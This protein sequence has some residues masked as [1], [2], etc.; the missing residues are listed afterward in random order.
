MDV[1]E[2]AQANKLDLDTAMTHMALAS[3]AKAA[4]SDKQSQQWIFNTLIQAIDAHKFA[5]AL[6][7]WMREVVP[8]AEAQGPEPGEVYE[9]NVSAGS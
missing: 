3:L 4:N 2:Y 6:K 9:E 8:L 1:R 5:A 7:A